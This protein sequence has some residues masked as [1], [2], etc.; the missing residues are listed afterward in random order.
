[1]NIKGV[2]KPRK[3]LE[4]EAEIQFL[5][6]VEGATQWWRIFRKQALNQELRKWLRSLPGLFEEVPCRGLIEAKTV[7]EHAL[8]LALVCQI[9]HDWQDLGSFLGNHHSGDTDGAL[10]LSA[11]LAKALVELHSL[12]L[13]HGSLGH[14]ALFVDAAGGVRL[15]GWSVP[16]HLG[17]PNPAP[18][19]ES[20]HA[21]WFQVT[22]NDAAS[23]CFAAACFSYQFFLGQFPCI[24]VDKAER[25][26]SLTSAR[27]HLE[28]LPASA[29]RSCLVRGLAEEMAL[30]P[31]SAEMW[32]QW[33][34]AA[35]CAGGDEGGR[36]S[37]RMNSISH[38]SR[39]PGQIKASTARP[40]THFWRYAALGLLLFGIVGGAYGLYRGLSPSGK[41]SELHFLN[42]LVGA[43]EE[44][45]FSHA[46]KGK[47]FELMEAHE[48]G[49]SLE[50][51]VK[52]VGLYDVAIE[53]E[54]K[55][56][57]LFLLREKVKIHYAD[58]L[59]QAIFNDELWSIFQTMK[60]P[61]DVV[62]A[63]GQSPL[64]CAIAD[65]D[66]DLVAKLLDAGADPKY[67]PG[68]ESPMAVAEREDNLGGYEERVYNYQLIRDLLK[69]RGA[70]A[71]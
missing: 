46:Q 50:F 56:L 4:R 43:D 61:L 14:D 9:P 13:F 58:A 53:R 25:L 38:P 5:V 29:L 62:D 67:Q 49:A 26:R 64:L 32:L 42:L 57:L 24:G 66:P 1:M 23:D 60:A 8:G 16:T 11:S 59:N 69:N 54:D 51:L 45:V 48:R 20:V 44:E 33:L 3:I 65:G 19:G 63:R 35:R 70:T 52:G 37:S 31:K 30:R 2:D 39:L 18:F 10:H 6:P 22:G 12:G 40:G 34:E 68:K 7:V 15:L 28:R 21:H 71:P 17:H 27:S 36:Q 47:I 55:N 41:K